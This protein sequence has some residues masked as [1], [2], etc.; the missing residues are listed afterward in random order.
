MK[1]ELPTPPVP[2]LA[3]AKGQTVAELTDWFVNFFNM[4]GAP[5]NYRSGTKAIRSGY[6]GLHKLESLIAGCAREKTTVGRQSNTDIVTY[7]APLAFGRTTQVFDLSPRRFRFGR[8]HRAAYRIP[9]FF[10]EDGTI[11]VYY[12]QPRKSAGLEFDELCMVATIVKTYLLDTEF[13]GLTC[14]VEF[15]D[16]G[17]PSG[18]TVRRLRQYSLADLP[19]WPERRLTERLTMIAAA[20]D[21]ASASGRVVLRHRLRPH[22]EPEMPL[23]D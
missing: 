15:V 1:Q 5:F 2:D 17:I 13:Y 9:F 8:D 23:F 16:V 6:K 7:A 18:E 3:R 4:H 12:L 14:D 10:V 22:P 11:H 21:L 20:L 19:L